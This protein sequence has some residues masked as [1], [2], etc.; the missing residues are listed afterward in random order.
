MG[1]PV[2]SSLL[3]DCYYLCILFF[4]PNDLTCSARRPLIRGM[5]MHMRLLQ[6][7]VTASA[8]PSLHPLYPWERPVGCRG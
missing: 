8:F 1:V 5:G 6:I 3:L 7:P 2:L 4:Y